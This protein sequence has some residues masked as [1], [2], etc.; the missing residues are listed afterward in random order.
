MLKKDM[1]IPCVVCLKYGILQQAGLIYALRQVVR[2]AQ[3]K[4]GSVPWTSRIDVPRAPKSIYTSCARG[5]P[6]RCWYFP[7]GQF[8][9]PSIRRLLAF[10]EEAC[11][12]YL[13]IFE[14]LIG[15]KRMKNRL[16]LKR[17]FTLIELLVVIAIIAI[18]IALLLPA[19]Q[20]AREAARR[21]KCQNNLKQLGLALHNYHDVY[22]QFTPGRTGTGDG[23][24]N[25]AVRLSPF[26]GLL[27]YIDQAALFN[28]IISDG[29]CNQGDLPWDNRE[30]WNRNI[31]ALQCP[32]DFLRRQD[33]GKNSYVFNHGDR[34]TSLEDSN[35]RAGRGMFLGTQGVKIS[36]VKDGTSNT[37]AMS[38][39]RRSYEYGAND[40]EVYGQVRRSTAGVE[41][42]PSLCIA[43]LDPN[44]KGL[45]A[46]GNADRVRG[47][48]WGDGRPAFTGF[49]TVLP[50]NSPSCAANDSAEDPNN[51]VY[52]ASSAHVGGVHCLMVDGAVRFISENIDTGNITAND[53]DWNMRSSPYGVW[54][55]LGTRRCGEVIGEF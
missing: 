49:Q 6:S 4:R 17:G 8:A 53:M 21:S 5:N 12:C 47:D 50:P 13:S 34:L 31:V 55:A 15:E 25:N 39:I 36:D 42:N 23:S 35:M 33:R 2:R 29:C 22:G 54:G 32:S 19:V 30:W 28:E 27:P 11:I 46:S 40:L 16:T 14:F 45:F 44:D 48:R 37:I 1:N 9:C 20:Q 51:A 3:Q 24:E 38:E 43:A 41:N 7:P 26:F 52:S 10:D 18:L